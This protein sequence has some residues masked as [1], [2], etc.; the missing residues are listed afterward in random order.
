[1]IVSLFILATNIKGII[2]FAIHNEIST[3]SVALDVM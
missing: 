1:M 3:D 2:F